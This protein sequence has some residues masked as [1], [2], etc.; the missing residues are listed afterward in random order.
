MSSVVGGFFLRLFL[1]RNFRP[2]IPYFTQF[3]DLSVFRFV[4][5]DSWGPEWEMIR[6]GYCV[7]LRKVAA[8]S[9]AILQNKKRALR[10][11]M[12]RNAHECQKI[13]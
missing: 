6:N 5:F 1:T 12:P 11:E 8:V 13:A 4:F 3:T 7:R 10:S 2:K 9:S